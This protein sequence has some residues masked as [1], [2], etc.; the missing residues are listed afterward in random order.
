MGRSYWMKFILLVTIHKSS[1]K[2]GVISATNSPHMLSTP[3]RSTSA[4]TTVAG[5]RHNRRR[6]RFILRRLRTGRL[7]FGPRAGAEVG[8]GR[9]PMIG[10]SQATL[11]HPSDTLGGGLTRGFRL[12]T[13]RLYYDCNSNDLQ[14]GTPNLGRP[15]GHFRTEQV[16]GFR[17]QQ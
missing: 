11:P 6:R 15:L 16:Y 7:H 2:K 3:A 8:T 10:I 12:H 9:F 4:C 1:L 13:Q 17:W 14:K 5:S